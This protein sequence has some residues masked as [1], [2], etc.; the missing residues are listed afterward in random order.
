M[1]IQQPAPA[2]APSEH[3]STTAQPSYNFRAAAVVWFIVGAV[4]IFIAARF[5]GKLFGASA[6]SAFVNFIYQVSSPMVAPFTGIFGDTG[7][8]TNTFETASLVAIVVYAVVAWGLVALIRIITAPK[9]T[10]PANS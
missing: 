7:T 1:A 10:K 2:P 5:L 6:Q 4:E 9:G 3:V 8:K